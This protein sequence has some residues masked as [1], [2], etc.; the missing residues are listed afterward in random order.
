MTYT[1]RKLKSI[2]RQVLR[3]STGLT[4]SMESLIINQYESS[5]K[6]LDGGFEIEVPNEPSIIE[7]AKEL[8]QLRYGI[9]PEVYMEEE[10]GEFYILTYYGD[11]DDGLDSH[12][13]FD[14]ELV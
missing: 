5:L 12:E 13:D 11:P 14:P 2:I 3:E 10:D 8:L 6:Q 1:K 7:G 9:D 4:R